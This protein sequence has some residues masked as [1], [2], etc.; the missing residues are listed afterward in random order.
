VRRS[1][2][3]ALLASVVLLVHDL[4]GLAQDT[5]PTLPPPSYGPPPE[6]SRRPLEPPKLEKIGEDRYRIGTIELD[7]KRRMIAAP[8]RVL[9]L[10]D[11]PLEY[12][13]VAR[14][15]YKGYESMLELDST[16]SEF[17]LACILIG[18]DAASG[19]KPRFQFDTT[20]VDGMRV[21]LELR[22][23]LDG[24]P[25]ERVAVHEALIER[26]TSG[27]ERPVSDEW[28]YIGSYLE[29]NSSQF[30]ADVSGTVVG[31]VHDPA[32]IVE[33]RAGL[34]IGGYGSVQARKGRLP[35]IGTPITLV[36][37]LP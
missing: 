1:V 14:D 22:W 26:D 15:G 8:G 29:P 2:V 4:P 7:R 16:A 18:L 17:N 3:A 34:G 24:Q 11:A 23:K 35:P 10:D 28:I 27:A 21:S 9:H 12:V 31:F 13:A 6:A 30:R 32:S 33:H 20:P 25:A 37:S 19:T 5:Q 36:L